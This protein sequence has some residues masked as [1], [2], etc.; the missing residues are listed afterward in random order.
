MVSGS[1]YIKTNLGN[2]SIYVAA[3]ISDFIFTY[4]E[5]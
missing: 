3:F 2:L 5:A 4:A 1:I